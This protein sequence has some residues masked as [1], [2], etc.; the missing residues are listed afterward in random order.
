MRLDTEERG[1]QG[2]VRMGQNIIDI[3]TNPVKK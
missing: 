2:I 3:I 1:H